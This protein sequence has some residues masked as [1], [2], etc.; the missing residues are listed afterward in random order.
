M[1]RELFI[2]ATI[3]NPTKRIS[4]PFKT[5]NEYLEKEFNIK[6]K[7]IIAQARNYVERGNF[8]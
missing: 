3:C 6:N 2:A 8:D 1:H 4:Y 7:K 5:M